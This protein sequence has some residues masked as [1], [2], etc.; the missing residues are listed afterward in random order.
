M[1]LLRQYQETKEKA[2]SQKNYSLGIKNFF[3]LL[4]PCYDKVKCGNPKKYPDYFE[5]GF[6]YLGKL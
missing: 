2:T 5:L 3:V 4:S 6:F 1:S